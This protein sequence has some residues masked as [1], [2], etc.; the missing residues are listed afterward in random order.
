M[1]D[2]DQSA[3]AKRLREARLFAGYED[4]ASVYVKFPRWKPNSYKS[5]ENGNGAFSF[6]N[7]L[8]YAEAFGVNPTWLYSGQGPMVS[9]RPPALQESEEVAR[10]RLERRVVPPVGYV[11]A[12]ALA[13]YYATTDSGLGEV[14]APDNANE[15]T[16]AVEIRGSSLGPLFEQWLVF[17]DEVRSPVTADMLHRLCIVGLPDDRVLVKQIKPAGA[18]NRFHLVSNTS[19]EPVIWDQEVLWAAR[20][21]GMTPR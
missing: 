10:L 14:D 1:V 17:Y 19:D 18:P 12:G 6:K 11:G 16:V 2:D 7:A 15:N 8:K 9:V 3:R 21:R 4:L 20:V 13:H 5:H